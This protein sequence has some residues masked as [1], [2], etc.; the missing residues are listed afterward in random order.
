MTS[1]QS[2]L[3]PHPDMTALLPLLLLLAPPSRSLYICPSYPL[4]YQ[5]YH[6]GLWSSHPAVG[7]R[8]ALLLLQNHLGRSSPQPIGGQLTNP[9]EGQSSQPI[10]GQLSQ[11]IGGQLSQPIGGQSFQPIGGRSSQPIRGRSSQPI[12]EHEGMEAGIYHFQKSINLEP[13]LKELGVGFILRQLAQV[14]KALPPL[15]SRKKQS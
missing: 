5:Q 7:T 10:G 2:P 11:P 6:S 14:S 12:K 4:C 1:C 15:G 8:E 9:I 13:Y 3:P